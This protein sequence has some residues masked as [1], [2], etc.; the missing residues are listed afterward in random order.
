M[1][2]VQPC[3]ALKLEIFRND[4]LWLK[5]PNKDRTE[6]LSHFIR[7]EIKAREEENFASSSSGSESDV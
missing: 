2:A 6:P 1:R 3:R 4:L 5:Y 7:R